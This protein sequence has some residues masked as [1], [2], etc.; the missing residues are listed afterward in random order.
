MNGVAFSLSSHVD[1]ALGTKNCPCP[2]APTIPLLFGCLRALPGM[3]FFPRNSK[4]NHTQRKTTKEMIW[5]CINHIQTLVHITIPL[6]LILSGFSPVPSSPPSSG[7][8]QSEKKK[9]K[10][11]V[12]C[13]LESLTVLGHNLNSAREWHRPGCRSGSE[14]CSPW[15]FLEAAPSLCHCSGL[16]PSL[17][18][19]HG[20]SLSPSRSPQNPSR[21]G[22]DERKYFWIFSLR[23]EEA[24]PLLLSSLC[25]AVS[26]VKRDILCSYTSLG[27][28]G[29]V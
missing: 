4:F 21:G 29:S 5:M 13:F 28:R 22:A 19:P 15:L 3:D 24:A 14:F 26:P 7:P 20:H 12:T 1:P 2:Q 10:S 23:K 16:S 6:A 9:S 8:W 11:P 27:R 25:R 18:C 17:L